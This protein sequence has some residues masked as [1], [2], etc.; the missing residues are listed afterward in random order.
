MQDDIIPFPKTNLNFRTNTQ[1][2]AG[3][4][5]ARVIL[6]EILGAKGTMEGLQAGFSLGQVR[7]VFLALKHC[8]LRT[9]L[10]FCLVYMQRVFTGVL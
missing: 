6:G 4:A 7:L 8:Q 5:S 1:L 2:C 9:R 3:S 10:V